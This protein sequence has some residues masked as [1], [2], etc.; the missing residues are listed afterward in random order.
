MAE[1]AKYWCAV[2]YPESMIEDW[3]VKISDIVQV[4]Y[5]YCKHDKDIDFETNTRKEHIH[6]ILAF[7]NTTTYKHALS[8]FQLLQPTCGI[9]KKV[10]G[11]RYMYEYL[12]HNTESCRKSG[13]HI[14]DVSERIC[15]NNFD[16]GAYEQRSLEE[17]RE[18][19]KQLKRY[20]IDHGIENVM[21]LDICLN[22]DQEIDEDLRERYEDVLLGYSGYI[23]N[24][25][26]GVYLYHCKN[27]DTSKYYGRTS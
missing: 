20:I 7:N 18:D 3:E 19:A 15:G 26:K 24:I 11:I 10:I 23:N 2:L 21:E 8:I 12:I 13:K 6:L 5:S 14:Y 4:P 9:C 17:K 16:I 1:K 22:S 25:C 27:F